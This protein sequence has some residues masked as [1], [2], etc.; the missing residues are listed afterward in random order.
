MGEQAGRRA[1]GGP[2]AGGG[3][4]DGRRQPGGGQTEGGAFVTP[5]IGFTVLK[6]TQIRIDGL[7]SQRGGHA[8]RGL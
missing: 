5:K 3:R 1:A 2:T 7:D 6:G 8:V 4:A